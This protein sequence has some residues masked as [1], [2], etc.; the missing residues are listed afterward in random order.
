MFLNLGSYFSLLLKKKFLIKTYK[1]IFTCLSSK[2][3][4]LL[5]F[6]RQGLHMLCRLA[7]NS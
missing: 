7:S 3:F 6:R 4:F 5:C 2:A 1:I